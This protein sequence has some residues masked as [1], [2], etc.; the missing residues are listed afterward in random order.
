ME[1]TSS[2]LLRSSGSDELG[3][4]MR[5]Y[6]AATGK[7]P[8]EWEDEPGKPK[9]PPRLDVLPPLCPSPAMQSAR[10]TGR[11]SRRRRSLKRPVESDSFEGC[12]PVKFHLGRAMRS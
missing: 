1:D 3:Q 9:S 5:V 7:V 8:F 4:S 12:L 10:L 6:S 2:A 11:G